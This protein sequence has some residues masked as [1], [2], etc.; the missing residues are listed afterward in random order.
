MMRRPASCCPKASLEP[1][2]GST[3]GESY[4]VRLSSE[5]TATTTVTI[6]GHSGTDLTL[7]GPTNGE[8]TF[9]SSNWSTAQTVT[10]KAAQ[11]ADAVNDKET[12]THTGEGGD[13]AGLTRDLP[14][15][16]DDDDEA[17]IVLSK[18]SLGPAEGSS[19]GESYTVRLSSEPTAT[20]TVTITGHSDTDLTLTGPTSDEL[21]FTSS[22]W[23]T[24]QT[25]TVKAAQDDD[26]YGDTATLTHSASGGDYQGMVK[27]LTVTV[28]D[29]ETASLV[30]S[31]TSLDPAEGNTTGPV[32]HSEAVARA[33]RDHHR[34]PERSLGD[35]PDADGSHR[36]RAHLHQLRLEHGPGRSR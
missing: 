15:T 33:R 2:E 11:D 32:V 35:G 4:T 19:S 21:T 27:D 3:S 31:K 28:D 6:T 10:V 18:A 14:V 36:R 25:V 22:N 7:S 9:T 5:P 12:L 1:V 13:Y 20:T 30:L 8:L 26:A 17:G 23:N 29:D 16:V 24:A 34:G